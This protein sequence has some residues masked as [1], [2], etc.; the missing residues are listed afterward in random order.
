MLSSLL[1]GG[2]FG[3]AAAISP[4]PFQA[5]LVSRVA[6]TGW[7]RTLPASLAPLISDVPIAFLVL[8]VLD[9]LPATMQHLL[10]AS[11]GGL[12]LYLAYIG[13]RQWRRT[14]APN[15]QRSAP[16]ALLDAVLV[17]ALNPNAYLGWAFV[18]GPATIAAWHEHPSHAVAVVGAFY[19]TF[20]AMLVLFI[21]LIG[22]IRFLGSGAQRALIAASAFAMAAI[23]LY[24]L[25]S[26][27]RT[28]GAV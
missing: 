2:G 3:F 20:V 19:G 13:F 7:R 10:R 15:L 23:G 12:L 18:L 14:E 21:F 8:V 22:T 26:G 5:F 24:L 25:V 9:Q 17:N 16:R 27:V 4:G 28:L 11:G 6:A 1:I